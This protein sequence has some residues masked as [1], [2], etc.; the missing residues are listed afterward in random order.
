MGCDSINIDKKAG[1]EM[2]DCKTKPFVRRKQT[3]NTLKLQSDKM[4]M[5]KIHKAFLEIS[6]LTYK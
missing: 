5:S 1:K 2:G 3:T 6:R 4:L